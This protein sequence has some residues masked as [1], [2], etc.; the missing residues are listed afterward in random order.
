MEHKFEECKNSMKLQKYSTS[1]SA[2]SGACKQGKVS[3]SLSSANLFKL[4]VIYTDIHV[5]TN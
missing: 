3:A 4:G 2:E 5:T 1:Q